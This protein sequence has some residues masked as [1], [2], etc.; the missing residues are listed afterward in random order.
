MPDIVCYILAVYF[1][2]ISIVAVA[3]TVKDKNIA[4]ENRP[5]V[6]KYGKTSK[7]L[8]KRIPERTLLIIAALGGSVAMLITMKRIRHKTS[9]AKFMA[10]IPAIIILQVAVIVGILLLISR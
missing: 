9:K 1:V 5:L 2:I 6:E 4:V 10:G 7:R 3:V 8:K